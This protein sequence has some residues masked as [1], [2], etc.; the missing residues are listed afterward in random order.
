M[1]GILP[2]ILG[3]LLFWPEFSQSQSFFSIRRERS[4]IL[5]AGT[6]AS[7]YY[8]ELSNPGTVI[9]FLPNVNVGLQK[10]LTPQINVRV[11]LNWF[12]LKGSDAQAD[13]QSRKQRGLSFLSNN[14]EI[15][16]IGAFNLFANGNRYYRRP[17]INIYAF[18]GIGLLYFNPTSQ[19][20]GKSYSLAPLHTEG[21]SY[22]RV[23]PVIPL[24]LG[25]RLKTGPN[26]NVVI[27]GGYRKTFTDYLDDVSTHY[28]APGS[29]PIA[30][31][32]MNPNNPTYNTLTPIAS[33]DVNNYTAGSK[34]GDPNKTDSYFL[35]NI[36][37]EYYL[38]MGA[39]G[40]RGNGLIS[41]KKRKSTYRYNK[42]GGVRR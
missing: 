4:W 39:S 8:G 38:P 7:T 5:T 40:R 1:K 10:Y 34:R 11:E 26:T 22:S 20:N 3:L 35:L 2:L 18:T 24:G 41:N 37:V 30:N 32:F 17:S 31:Y 12:Q 13:E 33:G 14:F 15:S 28:V 19:L 27:E 23:V 42:R 29:D 6:G 21:V 36:K 9:K 25:L 16:A